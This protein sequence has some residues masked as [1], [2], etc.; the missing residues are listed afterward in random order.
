MTS[1]GTASRSEGP[2]S[3]AYWIG[4]D[5]EPI[6]P[7]GVPEPVNPVES[8]REVGEW[9]SHQ[10]GKAREVEAAPGPRFGQAAGQAQRTGS[11]EDVVE[12]LWLRPA[13]ATAAARRGEVFN[14]PLERLTIEADSLEMSGGSCSWQV[15]VQT[16]RF[17]TR[18][19]TLR[20]DPSPSGVFTVLQLVPAHPRR[21]RT[22]SFVAAGVPAI[23]QL[24]NRLA[25]VRTA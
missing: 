4:D 18:E 8:L 10:I 5:G 22:R 3:F 19:A 23:S 16:G 9:C 24:S 25:L 21:V 2:A 15:T 6:G 13:I 20:I 1:T 11:T 17:R 14:P 12:A 7:L